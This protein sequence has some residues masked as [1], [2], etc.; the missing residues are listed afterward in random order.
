[1]DDQLDVVRTMNAVKGQIFT[2]H[3]WEDRTRGEQWVPT[4]KP[5]HFVLVGDDFLR[6]ASNNAV[7]S[8]QRTFEFQALEPGTHQIEFHKRL[9]WKF[10][11]EDRR[12]FRIHVKPAQ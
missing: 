2:I 12:I 6:T 1:M 8:G 10:T 5:Q 9:A 11:S 7:D 3:L 4:Y